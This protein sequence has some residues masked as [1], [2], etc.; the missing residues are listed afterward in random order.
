M[1]IQMVTPAGNGIA[2]QQSMNHE[3]LHHLSNMTAGQAI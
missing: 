2:E 3:A 1:G